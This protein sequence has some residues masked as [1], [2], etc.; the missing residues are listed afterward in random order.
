MLGTETLNRVLQER[1]N[2]DGR[3][4]KRGDRQ[5]RQGDRV[6]CVR[7]RYDVDVFN[8]DVGVVVGVGRGLEVQFDG[9]L[10]VWERDDL[11]LLDLAYAITVH[12][13]Q[14]SEYPAVVLALHGS[15]GLMLRR[16]LF[17][18]GLTRA[19]RFLCVV[20]SPKAWSRAVREQG[21]DVRSTLL[22]SRLKDEGSASLFGEG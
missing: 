20:G 18:T 19:K 1:L 6:I 2:P 21:G 11:G 7:N 14:G 3:E 17:Y 5:W 9:R 13:S 15:H 10:V 16:R 4:L 8:G 12:K 22:K